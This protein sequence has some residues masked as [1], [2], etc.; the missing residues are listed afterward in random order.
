M[1]VEPHETLDSSDMAHIH[2]KGARSSCQVVTVGCLLSDPLKTDVPTVCDL[3]HK[4][5][6]LSWAE[7]GL[8]L[9]NTYG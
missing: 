1:Y 6:C 2:L 5:T 8:F 4:I 7:R 3:D 9:L